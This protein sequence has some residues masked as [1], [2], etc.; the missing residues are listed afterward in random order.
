MFGFFNFVFVA[1]GFF[2]PGYLVVFEISQR[3]KIKNYHNT[4]VQRYVPFFWWSTSMYGGHFEIA[5]RKSQL[6][7][8]IE[9]VSIVAYALLSKSSFNIIIDTYDQI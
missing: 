3:C 6:L 1:C 9:P 8:K 2:S 5:C 4:S 7:H